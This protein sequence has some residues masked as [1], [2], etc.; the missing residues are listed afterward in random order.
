MVTTMV[1]F[2][3]LALVIGAFHFIGALVGTHFQLIEAY[4]MLVGGILMIGVAVV[5][6]RLNILK[7]LI[8]GKES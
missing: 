3:I 8:E 1:I 5:I 7:A 6:E 2:G 4:I